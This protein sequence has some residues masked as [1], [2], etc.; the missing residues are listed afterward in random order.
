MLG[1]VRSWDLTPDDNRFVMI[2]IGA[3]GQNIDRLIVVENFF[4][5][6]KTRKA[7]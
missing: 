5:E 3:G 7:Q 4:P 1:G 2:R 6:L